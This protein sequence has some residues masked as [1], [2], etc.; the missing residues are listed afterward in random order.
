MRHQIDRRRFLKLLSLLPLVSVSVLEGRPYS[1]AE[2]APSQSI[3]DRPNILILLFDTLCARHLSIHGYHRDTAPNLTRFAERAT[4]Y[5]AHHAAGNFTTPGTASLLS[6]TYPWT[7]RALHQGGVVTKPFEQ[8]NLFKL[9]ADEYNQILYTQNQWT[10]LLLH[11][12]R[13]DGD[14]YVTPEAF[15][16][17]DHTFPDWLFPRDAQ[18]AFRSFDELLFQG[19]YVPG[20]PFLALANELK[21]AFFERVRSRSY[22]DLYPRGVPM[23]GLDMYFLLEEMTE[24]LTAMLGTAQQPFL[25]YFHLYPPHEPYR[26]RHEF[27]GMFDDGWTSITKD[28]HPLSTV[29]P[30]AELNVL[31][32]QYDE[33][34]AH[35]DAEFGRL[36]DFMD[37]TGIL[38]SSYVVITSDHGQMFERGVHGHITEL[39]FEP[40]IHIPLLISAPG[41]QQRQD[42]TTP[43]SNVDLLPT[44]LHKLGQPIPEWCEGEILPGPGQRQDS[45]ERSIFAVE[46]K[47]NSAHRPLSVATLA[48]I[49]GRYKLIHYLGY[50]RY[51]NRFE[52]YDLANDPEE[53]ED[54]YA[55]KKSI[56]ADLQSE[57]EN[58]LKEVDR[59]YTLSVREP[60]HKQQ[61]RRKL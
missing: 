30:Q 57:L 31:R 22:A 43:T 40:V 24:G 9:C 45:G 5:H 54:L 38:D 19:N 50:A 32:N 18:I 25:A 11:Q 3:Q 58:K 27:V 59:A 21:A 34:V 53:L 4:V 20:S 2:R 48:L 33:Y 35:T 39:L 13:Q 51:D 56:A 14:T 46:A 55:T 28:P 60:T 49:R 61:D 17:A 7:H 44:L 47:R 16:L 26:P 37:R 52:L 10:N 12:F 36:Y 1:A 8:R 23:Q 6:G 29:H 15:C 42:V 41:Q